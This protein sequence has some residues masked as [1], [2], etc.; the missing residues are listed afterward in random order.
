MRHVAEVDDA[1]HLPL[2]VDEHVPEGE[3]PVHHLRAE[4]SQHWS[5]A[6]LEAI[7]DALH[8]LAALVAVDVLEHRP[9]VREVLRVPEELPS[10]RGM[11][12]AAERPPHA[13]RGAAELVERRRGHVRR[14]DVV[15]V[16]ERQ[17]ADEVTRAVGSVHLRHERAVG[18]RKR[19]RQREP[20]VRSRGVEDRGG[21]H[22]Q[23]RGVL[24]AVGDL[25]RDGAARRLLDPEVLIALAPELR[26]PSFDAEDARRDGLGVGGGEPRR[27]GR[28]HT[29]AR[30][31]WR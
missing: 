4:R 5:D 28:E 17:Q 19:F 18:G 25:Q 24:A 7:E 31:R 2:A 6:G 23:H 27:S 20:G 15:A 10:G 14:V 30:A 16:E 21:L 11:E 26:A 3:V 22:L 1:G 8:D 9:E 13:R 29:A 12:E